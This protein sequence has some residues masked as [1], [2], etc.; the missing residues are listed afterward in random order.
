MAQTIIVDTTPGYRMPTIYYSQGDIGRTFSIDLQSRFG[1]SLPASPTITIQA[2]KPS[3][4]GFSVASTSISGAVVTFTV[5]ET[6]SNEAG[7]FPAELKI[8]K[9]SVTLFTANFYIDCEANAHPEGTTDGDI[10]HIMPKFMSVTTTT[11]SAGDSATYTFDPETNT[12]IFGIPKGADGSLASQVLAADY[13]SS[14]TYAVGDYVYYNGNLYRCTTAITTAE[15]WTSGHWTQVAL[16]DD[17]TDLKSAFTHKQ[18]SD[19][20]LDAK[21]DTYFDLAWTENKCVEPYGDVISIGGVSATKYYYPVKAGDILKMHLWSPGSTDVIALYDTNKVFVSSFTTSSLDTEYTVP[22]DGFMRFS[23]EH[24]V[25]PNNSAY[26]VLTNPKYKTVGEIEDILDIAETK[27]FD[28]EWVNDLYLNSD[29]GFVLSAGDFASTEKFYPVYEGQILKLNLCA[30]GSNESAVAFYDTN[31]TYLNRYERFNGVKH[32]RVAQNGYARFSTRLSVIPTASA[33]AVMADLDKDENEQKYMSANESANVGDETAVAFVSKYAK[34]ELL[35]SGEVTPQKRY[36][37][38]GFDD[39]RASDFESIIPIFNKYRANATFN[40]IAT[41]ADGTIS[42]QDS[43][44]TVINNCHEIG[45]HSLLHYAFPYLNANFNGQDPSSLDGAQTP[46][47][48]NAMMRENAGSGKNAFDIP[49]TDSVNLDGCSV[50]STW[51]ALTD[52]ECQ[53]I[54]DSFSVLKN[55]IFAPLID[56]LSNKYLGTTGRSVGSYD[57]ATGKYTHGIF[58]GCS[59]SENQEVW[60]RILSIMQ[61]YYKDQFGVPFNFKCWSLPGTNS[62]YYGLAYNGKKYF[63]VD[64]T[65]LF[66][67]NSRFTSSLTGETRSFAEALA[68]FGYLYTHD[69]A[70]PSRWDG[71]TE[72]LMRQQFIMNANL[73]KKDCIAY[74]T[75]RVVVYSDISSQ[76]PASFF[77]GNAPKGQQMYEAQGTFKTFIDSLRD[78]T[79]RGIIRGEVIDSDNSYSMKTWFDELL[80]FCKVNNIEVITKSQANDICFNHPIRNGNLLYNP[81]F[82]NSIKKAYPNAS[83]IPSAP[84]GVEGSCEVVYDSD[85]TP[86]L[87][88]TGEVYIDHYG[89]PTGKLTLKMDVKNNASSQYVIV[90]SLKNNDPY[91]RLNDNG[92]ILATAYPDS[93]TWATVTLTFTIPNAN[94]TEFDSVYSGMGDKICGIYLRLSGA[95]EVKNMSLTL[96]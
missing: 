74:P 57:S 35:Y 2:T 46:Y 32:I 30:T 92:H 22:S 65:K 52:A 41:G 79:A 76:Y 23:N 68:N 64:H 24:G 13:S 11:L 44:G 59:T 14:K 37:A 3:G 62:F 78:V 73:S 47:P 51:G 61:M 42:E 96:N 34:N 90:Y 4:L 72:R 33:Y 54:R 28:L 81:N 93:G 36:L 12:A 55:A 20:E 91:Y 60:E 87:K 6:M 45:D 83:N 63:D 75:N 88:T 21:N 48:T 70:Y 40:K 17:V 77:S 58:T 49:L 39:F 66:N 18:L 1:E 84:D 69:F 53:A 80:K 16:G 50:T 86:V 95:L 67:M 15:A 89:I 94:E 56:N 85:G 8:V 29:N 10:E 7:R 71:E 38:I 43:I 26:V 27:K 5:T 82:E 25:V 9:N 31:K 19:Y